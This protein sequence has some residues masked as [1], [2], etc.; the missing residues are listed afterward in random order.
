M[1]SEGR[2]CAWIGDGEHC[3]RPAQ[4]NSSYCERHHA[5]MYDVF[6]VEMA[7]YIIEKELKSDKSV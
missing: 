7:D 6:Y 2:V 1:T 5:R 4:L 3:S